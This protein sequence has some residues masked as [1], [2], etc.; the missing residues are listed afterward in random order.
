L[1]FYEQFIE[2]GGTK[3]FR[4]DADVANSILQAARWFGDYNHVD[5]QLK[6]LDLVARY[7]MSSNLLNANTLEILN[8]IRTICGQNPRYH[9][10]LPKLDL[11]ISQFIYLAQV[12]CEDNLPN[13]TTNPPIDV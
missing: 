3:G 9:H 11:M 13:F 4:F 1:E 5:K 12:A 10:C 8:E 2:G 7:Y 6:C